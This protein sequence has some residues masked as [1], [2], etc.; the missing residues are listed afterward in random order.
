MI[1]MKNLTKTFLITSLFASSF[2]ATAN[3]RFSFGA[4]MGSLYS[5]LGINAGLRTNHDFKY[6]SVGC[7]AYSERYGKICGAGAGW[8]STNWLDPKK[9]KHGVGVYMGIVGSK[10][11]SF[12]DAEARYGVGVGYH[13]F[14]NGIGQSGTNLGVTIMTDTDQ[15]GV[16]GMLQLGYQF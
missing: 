13:Y 11:V 6:I 12:Y 10:R 16:G 15:T 3:Q 5:G 9:H 7:V 4:G 8:I 14:F 1:S 2:N